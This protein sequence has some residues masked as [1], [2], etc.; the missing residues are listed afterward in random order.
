MQMI[1]T[2]PLGASHEVSQPI[3][4]NVSTSCSVITQMLLYCV[5]NEILIWSKVSRGNDE[6]RRRGDVLSRN[7]S[8]MLQGESVTADTVNQSCA[9]SE[10]VLWQAI[11]QTFPL[12]V[13]L[14]MSA[15]QSVATVSNLTSLT[16]NIGQQQQ[17]S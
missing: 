1:T 10:A 6:V 11:F 16:L 14:H 4:K 12:P 8:L 7:S 13:Y 15:S 2:S 9:K 3:V 17:S 5:G